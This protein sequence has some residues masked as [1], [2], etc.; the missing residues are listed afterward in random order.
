MNI[1]GHEMSNAKYKLEEITSKGSWSGLRKRRLTLVPEQ[2]AIV[3]CITWLSLLTVIFTIIIYYFIYFQLLHSFYPS[4]QVLLWFSSP[5][6]QGGEER[7]RIK[8][9]ASWCLISNWAE[10][11]TDVLTWNNVYAK[12][13]RNVNRIITS[14]SQ[15]K[16][17][18]K[19]S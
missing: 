18:A 17:N 7:G 2:L 3:L 15:N 13:Q 12:Y 10:T 5:F 8:Q 16:K 9:A 4:M 14:K 19:N 11:I 6:H 1:P